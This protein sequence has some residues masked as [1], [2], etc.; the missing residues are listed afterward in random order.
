MAQIRAS[1]REQN[2]LV[3]VRGRLGARDMRRLEHAC[4]PALTSAH[5]ALVVDVTRVTDMDAAARAHLQRMA[6]RGALILD[7]NHPTPIAD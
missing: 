5:L 1:T 4:S 3:T 6:S 2:T 7:R